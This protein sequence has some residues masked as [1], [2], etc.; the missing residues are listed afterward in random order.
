MED[1]TD[2][3][4]KR[5]FSP[6]QLALWLTVNVRDMN[7][8]LS[9]LRSVPIDKMNSDIVLFTLGCNHSRSSTFCRAKDTNVIYKLLMF[10]HVYK[11]RI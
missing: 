10:I 5:L 11:I 3:K 9:R 2:L 8:I 7:V 4:G 6:R 1:E